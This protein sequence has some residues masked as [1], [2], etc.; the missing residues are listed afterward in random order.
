MKDDDALTHIED[1]TRIWRGMA[2]CLLICFVVM[3]GLYLNAYAKK[4]WIIEERDSLLQKSHLDSTL[5]VKMREDA[6]KTMFMLEQGSQGKDTVYY[7][8]KKGNNFI[9]QFIKR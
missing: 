1:R 8:D 7:R 2:S 3:S 5:I 4:K 9:I 6:G